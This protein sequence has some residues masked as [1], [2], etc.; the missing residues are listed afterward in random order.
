MIEEFISTGYGL[1]VRSDSFE[2]VVNQ[3]DTEN[4][5]LLGRDILIPG[6]ETTLSDYYSMPVRYVGRTKE[7]KPDIYGVPNKTFHLVFFLDHTDDLFT[8]EYWFEKIF[9]VTSERFFCHYVPSGG[10][11][12]NYINGTWDWERKYKTGKRIKKQEEVEGE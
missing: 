12:Y 2:E 1:V 5:V 7:E 10:R 3:L 8:H 6:Q 11:D 9:Y 4:E